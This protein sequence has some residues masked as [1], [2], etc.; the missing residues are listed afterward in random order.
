[1]AR[2]SSTEFHMGER[3]ERFLTSTWGA[4]LAAAFCCLLWGSAF[5]CI[6][7]G[8]ALFDIAGT[9]TASQ[10]LFAGTRFLLA[11]AMVIVF[12]SIARRRPLAPKRTD[13]GGICLLALFQ[14][15]GQYA[16]FYLGLAHAAGTTSSVIEASANFFAIL[17]SALAFRKSGLP[18]GRWRGASWGLLAWFSSIL[19]VAW[20]ASRFHSRPTARG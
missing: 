10:M 17:L 7:I 14:T 15:F 13:V 20:A 12:V 19:V 1:M 11:G 6:K 2:A 9:D 8:Y 5:P 4:L 16:F 18:A 3:Q